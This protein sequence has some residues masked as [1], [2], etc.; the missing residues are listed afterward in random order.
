MFN[1]ARD[2][3]RTGGVGSPEQSENERRLADIVKVG[4]VVEADY[5]KARV[6]VGIG[7]PDDPEGYILTGWLPMAGGRSDEWNPIQIGE[8]VSV[9]AEAGEIQNGVVYPGSIYN[10]D[11]PAVGDR[12]DLWRKDFRDGTSVEYDLASKTMKTTV[13]GC[14]TTMTEETIVHAIGDATVTIQDGSIVLSAGGATLTLNGQGVT[15]SKKITGQDGL[16]VTG[17]EF[18]HEGK[19]VGSQHKHGNTMPGPGTTGNPI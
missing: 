9:I 4:R 18:T 2:P 5:P 11:H 17:S 13:G 19:N 3:A 8:A 6:R 7:D 16:A 10:E 1:L 15:S 12:G 14:T